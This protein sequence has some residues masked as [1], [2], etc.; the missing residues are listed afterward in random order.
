MPYDATIGAS[1][2]RDT[3]DASITPALVDYIAIPALSPAFDADWEGSGHLRRAIDLARTWIEAQPV[4]GM[5]VSMHELEGR[6]PVLLV[7]VAPFGEPSTDKTVVLYGHL[8]KQPEMTGWRDGLGPWKPVIEGTRLYG[9]GG[10]DD[11]YAAFASI[12]ALAAVQRAGGSH[13]RCVLVVEASGRIG[14]PRSPRPCRSVSR[15]VGRRR[16]CDLPR[17]G[18]CDVRHDVAHL[19]APGSGGRH[20]HRRRARRGRSQRYC[21][22]CCAVVVPPHAADP[23]PVE[24]ATTGEVLLPSATV[25][26]PQY[27]L[28]EAAAVVDEFGDAALDPFP[29]VEGLQLM[30]ESTI[31]SMIARTWKPS[32]SIVGAD[33]LPATGAAGNVLRPSTS[34]KVSLRLPP[35]ADP[36]AV[37]R[38]LEAAVTVDPPSCARVHLSRRRRRGLERARPRT[39]ARVGAARRFD[40]GFW[41]PPPALWR[42]W[43]YPVHGNAG[44]AIP[45]RSVRR[46]WCAR[47]KYQCPRAQ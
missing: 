27:R 47:S 24:D 1:F 43:Q 22:W 8:D 18:M 4:A 29:V 17:L 2:I 10:A 21:Q 46:H 16:F 38:E 7:E 32:L 33:G 42:G 40:R 44:P 11:G 5:T 3:W 34:V 9:R 31:D 13:G 23:R 45:R 41:S 19:V 28:A 25:E 37:L 15:L 39:L 12:T 26:I 20:H 35:S 14:K 6:T 36:G 30:T